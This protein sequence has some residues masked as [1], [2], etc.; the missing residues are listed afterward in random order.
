MRPQDL[1]ND[2][3][4]E[5]YKK[6]NIKHKITGDDSVG[7]SRYYNFRLKFIEA[8]PRRV[9]ISKESIKNIFLSD[10]KNDILLL[11]DKMKKG[12]DINPYQS[13][14]SFNAD[15]HDMLFNDWG[16]RHFHLNHNKQ[17]PNDYFHIRTGNLLFAKFEGDE[18]YILDVKHHKDKNVWSNTD[19]IRLIRNNWNHILEPYE[20][21]SGSWYPNFNDEE[22]GIV[23]NKGYIFSINVDDK[24]YMML[25]DGYAVSGD[26]MEATR[27]AIEVYRWIG[28]NLELFEKDVE[29]F[30][31]QLK[32]RMHL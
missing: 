3:L 30:K 4:F 15:Y 17:K 21:G 10:H 28:K 18:A 19:I 1:I 25:G 23:R 32:M 8:K 6:F 7:L 11:L 31:K 5:F 16:I 9:L 27:L 12:M 24:T 13:K 29:T 26:N 2:I 14:Q 22:I 20:V